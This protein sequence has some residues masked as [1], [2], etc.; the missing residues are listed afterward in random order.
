MT[1]N[2]INIYSNNGT[3]F[4]TDGDHNLIEVSGEQVP[5][6]VQILECLLRKEKLDD[7]FSQV[8]HLVDNDQDFFNEIIDWLVENKILL[9]P[10]N[11][12]KKIINIFFKN[13]KSATARKEFVN[14]LNEECLTASYKI[15]EDIQEANLVLYFAPIFEDYSSFVLLNEFAY[16]NNINILH[17]GIDRASFTLGPLVVPKQKTPCLRCS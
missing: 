3:L 2:S 10:I 16:K 14:I 5:V 4:I 6:I 15:C 11:Q 17:I 13:I 7:T 1:L 8:S 9:R 12:P